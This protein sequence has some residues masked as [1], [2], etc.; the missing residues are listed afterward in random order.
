MS[1]E[2]IGQLYDSIWEQG[3]PALLRGGAPDELL[4]HPEQDT[5]MSVALVFRPPEAVRQAIGTCLLQL[6]SAHPELYCYPPQ[7]LHVTVLDLLAGRPGLVCPPELAE[8]YARVIGQAAARVP[9][10]PVC[11]AGFT[12]SG[13]AVMARGCPGP[14]LEALRQSVR[15]AL[16]A[17]GLPLEER[18]ETRSCHIT[19]VRFPCPIA[20]PAGLVRQLDQWAGLPLGEC[21]IRK[22]EITYHNWYDSKKT[23]LAALPL[24]GEG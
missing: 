7:D 13:S 19:A 5:R 24:A 3:C 9:P 12:A 2:T 10:I 4:A 17:Q 6:Q 15:T 18:Y 21:T 16:R 20:D 1:A 11:F 22:I 14:E 8:G 23:R